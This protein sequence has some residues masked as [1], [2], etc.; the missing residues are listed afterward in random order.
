MGADGRW[1]VQQ[2]GTTGLTAEWRHF[3]NEGGKSD[4]S[5]TPVQRSGKLAEEP[6]P[7]PFLVP[8]PFSPRPF[9][10]PLRGDAYLL[11]PFGLFRSPT[12]ATSVTFPSET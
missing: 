11:V 7:A 10:D 2:R 12:S 4:Q 8:P 1:K 9:P 6:V 5:R 3:R